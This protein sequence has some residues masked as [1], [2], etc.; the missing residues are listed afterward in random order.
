MHN[1]Y[2]SECSAACQDTAPEPSDRGT[3]QAIT[4]HFNSGRSFWHYEDP[5]NSL[6]FDTIDNGSPQEKAKPLAWEHRSSLQ[7]GLR[8][9]KQGQNVLLAYLQLS[10]H[11]VPC[12]FPEFPSTLA[13]EAKV[14]WYVKYKI[15]TKIYKIPH[16]V[17]MIQPSASD[18]WTDLTIWAICSEQ[19]TRQTEI[20]EHV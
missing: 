18:P 3:S 11:S 13:G 4:D 7:W 12:R 9:G 15:Y 19:K 1:K 2:W 17:D 5:P 20:Q 8:P 16:V 14:W 6:S 10:F